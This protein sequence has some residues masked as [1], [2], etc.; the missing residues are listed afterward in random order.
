MYWN[1]TSSGPVVADVYLI[2]WLTM[3]AVPLIDAGVITRW[4]SSVSL[5]SS[6]SLVSTLMLTICPRTTSVRSGRATGDSLTTGISCTC[7]ATVAS[8]VWPTLLRTR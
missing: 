1:V 6:S 7:T 3:S 5:F 8:A 4:I 2:V